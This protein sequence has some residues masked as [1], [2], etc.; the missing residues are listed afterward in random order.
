MASP[1]AG[2]AAAK[3][4]AEARERMDP[5]S[6]AIGGAFRK[7]ARSWNSAAARLS[8]STPSR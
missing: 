6:H 3:V 4:V 2:T 5:T 7:G 1:R 8:P